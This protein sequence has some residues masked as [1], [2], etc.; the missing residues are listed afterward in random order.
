[1]LKQ[2]VENYPDIVQLTYRHFP[3]NSIHPLAQISSEASEAAGAQGEFWAYHDL[4]FETQ[5]QWSGLDIAAAT[6]FF[7]ELAEDLNLDGEQLRSDLENGTYTAYV[8]AMEEESINIGLGGTPSVIFDGE[9]ISGGLPPYQIWD[10]LVQLELLTDRQYDA[11]PEITIDTEKTYLATVAMES[12]DT[13][14]IELLTESAPETVNSFI[15]LANAG[16][17]DNVQ[18]H[19]VIPGFVAQTGD[20]T[21]T[22]Y[23]GP[24]Y[25]IPDE[26]DADLTMGDVGIVAMANSGPNTSGSQWFI[27]LADASQLDGSF[28]IFGRVIEGLDV[29]N[30]IT[31]RDPS[32]PL[33]PPGDL[34]ISISIEEK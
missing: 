11:P 27:T 23:G 34:I 16:W 25:T 14:T 7:V 18:F 26:I 21:G 6:D 15:F 32:D 24:G 13:F 28:T 3:L 33:A 20:P 8:S 22:G 31:E 19:R 12:G 30:G 4:L 10:A 17:F 1:M 2:L 29:V 5:G 9:L